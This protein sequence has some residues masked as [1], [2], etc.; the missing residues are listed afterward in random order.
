[1]TQCDQCIS[2][3]HYRGILECDAFP[4][5]IPQP[6]LL[7]EYDHREPYPGDQGIRFN[8]IDDD[9]SRLGIVL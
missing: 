8:P 4:D 9:T 1:M 6:I 5:G 7:G 2:C 3:R